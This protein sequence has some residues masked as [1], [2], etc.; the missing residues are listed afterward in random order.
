LKRVVVIGGGLAGLVASVQLA[1]A[2]VSCALVEKKVYPFHRVCGEYI[3]NE[4]VPFLKAN[5]LFP[6]KFNPPRITRFTLSS[7]TG[8]SSTMPL[9]LGGFGISRYTYDNFLFEKAKQLGVEFFLSE[10]VE[11]T[12]FEGEK[13][14]VRT[15][16]R[17]LEADVVIGSF[18]KRSRMDHLLQREFIRERSPYVGVKYHIRTQ[19]PDDLIALHNF[20]GGYCGMSNI[21]DGKTTLCYLTHRDHLKRFKNI[22]DMEEQVMFLNPL[23][24]EV[25]TH[26]EF[27]FER[28]EVINEVSFLT[29]SC[30]EDHVLMV[31]DSAGMIAPLCGNGMAMAI[32][33]AKMVSE[34]I[35]QFDRGEASRETMENLYTQQW[36]KHFRGRLWSGRQIQKLFGSYWASNLAV[37]LALY[38]RPVANTIMRNTHGEP[39]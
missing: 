36:N 24:K 16:A 1:K 18:G 37:N 4:A 31:G 29:K 19:H 10:E 28:P 38:I 15:S 3:S 9:D 8:K 5:D 7:A 39:F 22:R 33:A 25:F 23:L 32:H 2:G 14:Q 13:F 26:A 12:S 6:E 30:V 27:L 11:A 35:I 21:E 34:R 17:L 20:K